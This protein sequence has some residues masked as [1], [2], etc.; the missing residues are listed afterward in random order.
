MRSRRMNLWVMARVST[1][2]RGGASAARELRDRNPAGRKGEKMRTWSSLPVGKSPK[3]HYNRAMRTL[4][5]SSLIALAGAA[6]GW[7]SVLAQYIFTGADP[8]PA[9]SADPNI[10]A[11][12]LSRD[13]VTPVGTNTL[14]YTAVGWPVG[15]FNGTSFFEVTLNPDAGES[16]D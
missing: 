6:P 11:G 14:L 12:P 3:D 2:S 15:A 10:T 1:P 4:L 7:S 16:I 5:L 9:S 8:I 13:G